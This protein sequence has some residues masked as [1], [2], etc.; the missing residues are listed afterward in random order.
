MLFELAGEQILVCNYLIDEVKVT[1]RYFCYWVSNLHISDTISISLRLKQYF[2]LLHT[3]LF[4][5]E[6]LIH[7]CAWRMSTQVS[8]II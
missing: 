5:I 3:L 2:L 1:C 4:S 8:N 6:T 7:P